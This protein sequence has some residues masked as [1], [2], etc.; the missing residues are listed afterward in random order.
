MSINIKS[1]LGG[2]FTKIVL[3]VFL[4]LVVGIPGSGSYYFNKEKSGQNELVSTVLDIE[5]DQD[6]NFDPD[7]DIFPGETRSKDFVVHN[8]GEDGFPY[9]IRIDNISGDSDL[10]GVLEINLIF[11]DG[12]TGSGAVS[13]DTLDFDVSSIEGDDNY[14]MEVLLPED[15]DDVELGNSTCTFDLVAEMWIDD[16]SPG[17]AFFDTE[18]F[19]N[20]I[21]TGSF[22]VL[23]EPE[24]SEESEEF[25]QPAEFGESV[26]L[27]NSLQPVGLMEVQGIGEAGPPQNIQEDQDEQETQEMWDEQDLPQYT[28]SEQVE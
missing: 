27:E 4:A 10:C 13:L 9:K 21:S 28:E 24:E 12:S 25:E 17:Q 18:N 19:T 11:V 8:L 5:L 3:V 1:N 16:F 20:Q 23:S 2:T 15:A 14:T 6:D 7:E 22:E 26:E